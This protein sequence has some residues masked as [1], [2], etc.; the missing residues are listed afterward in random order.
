MTDKTDH[1][2]RMLLAEHHQR[3][4]YHPLKGAERP[5]SLAEAYD[6]QEA[7]CRLLQKDGAGE[8]AGYKIALTS[9]A[10]QQM[11]CVDQPLSGAIFASRVRKAP[12]VLKPKD[13]QHLGVECE[14][15]VRLGAP[16]TG[17]RGL[18]S[19]DSVAGAVAEILPAFELVDDRHADYTQIDAESLTADNAWNAGIVLGPACLEWE[20]FD[21]VESRG[22]LKINGKLQAEGKAGDALGHPLDALAWLANALVRRGKPLEA[23]A[24][25]M[26]GSI[27]RT[28]FPQAGDSLHFELEDCGEARLT[29]G[30]AG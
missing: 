6:V 21:F 28:V 17:A 12:A 1:I 26:T 16:L 2:A 4:P 29:I 8:I 27:V 10:M 13:F 5:S 19:R 9:K 7:F 25:V 22:L 15:A 3:M 24:L 11:V 23:G 14:L 20:D 18:Y 30:K